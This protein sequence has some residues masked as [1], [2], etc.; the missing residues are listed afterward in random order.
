MW[1][2]H[3]CVTDCA[4]TINSF[5]LSTSVAVS[6]VLCLLMSFGVQLQCQWATL[7]LLLL[8][9]QWDIAAL[10]LWVGESQCGRPARVARHDVCWSRRWRTTNGNHGTA[11]LYVVSLSFS[12]VGNKH[13]TTNLIFFMAWYDLFVLKVPLKPNQPNISLSVLAVLSLL[14]TLWEQIRAVL[15]FVSLGIASSLFRFTAMRR[16]TASA[17]Q[18]LEQLKCWCSQYEKLLAA[19]TSWMDMV[20]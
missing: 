6:I 11:R 4:A 10:L 1:P 20:I 3:L 18:R 19:W 16:E 15:L 9:L 8:P 13:F 5:N 17:I 2:N 14:E 7:H 12:S